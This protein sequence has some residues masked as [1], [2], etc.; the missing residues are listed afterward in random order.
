MS[1]SGTR[2]KVSTEQI[3]AA[4]EQLNAEGVKPTIRAVRE[5]LGNTGSPNRIQP[6]LAAWNEKS[7]P[8]EAAAAVL[9][10][11][12]QQSLGELFARERSAAVATKLEDIGDL[13]E[14]ISELTTEGARL[15]DENTALQEQSEILIAAQ[16]QAKAVA[17]QQAQRIEQLEAEQ[18]RL[19]AH[20]QQQTQE[21]ATAIAKLDM[22]QQQHQHTQ[23][24][25]E[26]A[27]AR[28]A[29]QV[30]AVAMAQQ[31]AAVAE[32]KQQAGLEAA[33]AAQK[34]IERLEQQ[35]EQAQAQ[36]VA[37]LDALQQRLDAALQQRTKDAQAHAQQLG[38]RDEQLHVEHKK[39]AGLMTQID[40]L[41]DKVKTL[42]TAKAAVKK[43]VAK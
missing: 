12:L 33:T 13:K 4:I 40:E 21:L 36:A 25:L 26:Q 1:T 24:Q 39:N 30:Q 18:Q 38:Q 28:Q 32:A 29:E 22:Q 14:Q 15:E 27:Q 9:S 6:L 35:L 11:G 17:G 43:E 2:A 10:E 37:K 19:Q 5:R 3:N 8:A 7:R 23:Q 16:T 20:G 42:T 31:A 41:S 34:R